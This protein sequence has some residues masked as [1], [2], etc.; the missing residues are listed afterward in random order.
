MLAFLYTPL[1]PVPPVDSQIQRA[2]GVEKWLQCLETLSPIPPSDAVAFD[3]QQ[4]FADY[5]RSCIVSDIRRGL[6]GKLMRWWAEKNAL[7]DT[8]ASRT[9]NEDR[10]LPASFCKRLRFNACHLCFLLIVHPRRISAAD[11]SRRSRESCDR[12]SPVTFSYS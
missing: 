1:E 5:L 2:V 7:V 4:S 9:A 3:I 8:P 11:G 6:S 10:L 12:V